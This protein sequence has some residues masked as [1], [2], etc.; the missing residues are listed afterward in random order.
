MWVIVVKSNIKKDPMIKMMTRNMKEPKLVMTKWTR[1]LILIDAST[2]PNWQI[3]Y[4]NQKWQ[5]F[6]DMEIIEID[7]KKV[8][9]LIEKKA[10]TPAKNPVKRTTRTVKKT[11]TKKPATKT[12]RKVTKKTNKSK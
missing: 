8:D 2:E 12:T 7:T 9:E 5:P 10:K 6:V 11:T 1:T 3:E 4:L